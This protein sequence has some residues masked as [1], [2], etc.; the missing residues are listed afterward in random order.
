MRR[1]ARITEVLGSE[2]ALMLALR[3]L[4][5]PATQIDLLTKL[6]K[7]GLPLSQPRLSGLMTRLGD[8]GVVTR[9]SRK[10]PYELAHSDETAAL[11]QHLAALGAAIAGEDVATASELERLARRTRLRPAGAVA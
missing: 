8:L 11:I 9:R 5:G 3:L 4:E 2:E 7:D 10:A 6:R 1:L